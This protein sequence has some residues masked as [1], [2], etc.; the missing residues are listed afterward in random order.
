MRRQSGFTLIELMVVITIVG[1]LAATALPVY[2]TWQQRSYGSEAAVMIK[3]ILNAE[4]VYYLDNNKFYPDD[5]TYEIYPDGTT[6]PADAIALIKEKLHIVIPVGHPLEY[7][8]TGSNAPGDE[9][10]SVT[11]RSLDGSFDLFKGTNEVT[12]SVDKTGKT[13]YVYASY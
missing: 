8:L 7:D 2:H 4:I 12:A 6:D 1:I 11:V 13:D 9:S 3:Q 10:F 5:V